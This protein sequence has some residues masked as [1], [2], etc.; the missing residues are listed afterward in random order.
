VIVGRATSR[1]DRRFGVLE[2][3]SRMFSG[4]VF[5]AGH[6]AD[7]SNALTGVGTRSVGADLGPVGGTFWDGGPALPAGLQWCS[8]PRRGEARR[9]VSVGTILSSMLKW[10][11]SSTMQSSACGTSSAE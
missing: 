5:G 9:S 11:R 8:Q 3:P 6:G 1:A 10:P 4:L 7:L 2:N